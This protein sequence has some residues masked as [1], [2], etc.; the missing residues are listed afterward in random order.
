MKTKPSKSRSP[1]KARPAEPSSNFEPVG[2]SYLRNAWISSAIVLI[3][4]A[5]LLFAQLGHYA[6]WDDEAVVG[7]AAKGV[8]QTGD[9]TVRLGD[10]LVAYRGGILVRDL[11]ERSTPPLATYFAAGSIGLLGGN[12]L[13]ARLPF[14]LAGLG[15]V[16]LCLAWA[17]KERVRLTTL[18]LLGGAIVG[19]VSFFLYSRQCRYYALVLLL[20]TAVAW[21]YLRWKC[22]RGQLVLLSGLMGLLFAANY[23]SY[24]ALLVCILADFVGWRRKEAKFA[25]AD[26]VALAV[27]QLILGLGVASIW[28]PL[29]TKFGGYVAQNDLWDRMVLFWWN[30]RD[31]NR[32]EFFVGALLLAAPVVAVVRKDRW[33]TRALVAMGLYVMVISA[34]SP[35]TMNNTTV[36]DIRYLIALLPLGWVIS[37]RTLEGITGKARATAL[38][39]AVVAFGTN[40]LHGGPMLSWGIRSTPVSFAGELIHPPTDPYTVAASWINEN[41]REG[42]SIWVEPDYMPYSLM[43]HAP[44]AIYAWQLTPPPQGQFASMPSIHFMGLVAPDYVM[45]FGPVVQQ[46]SEMLKQWNRASYQPVATLDAFWQDRYRPELFLRSFEPVKNFNR[47]TESIFVL[48]RTGSMKANP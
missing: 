12:S 27:P 45:A 21:L 46:V 14:A 13:A 1:G 3:V 26:W 40:L 31:M 36:A 39:L 30:L 2:P 8:L 43:F 7:L 11:H 22:S 10:N 29:S 6:L 9:T 17:L 41:V 42:E 15:C 44:K 19:N 34:V 5:V 38:A 48:K 32:C 33:L 20:S 4:S 37:V 24:L 18:W 35:Q 25:P 47:Q 23:M 28:N 16:A